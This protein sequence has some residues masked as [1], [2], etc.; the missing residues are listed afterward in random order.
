M[1]GHESDNDEDDHDETGMVDIGGGVKL[2]CI[3]YG[4]AP[5]IVFTHGLGGYKEGSQTKTGP[6][7]KTHL[8]DKG[9]KVVASAAV[10]HGF[11][12]VLYTS[13]G[14]G[15]SIGWEA[16]AIGENFQA[17]SWAGLA[18]DMLVF[19]SQAEC[20]TFIAGGASMG[21]ATAITAALQA[22]DRMRGLLLL[23]VPRAWE[24]RNEAAYAHKAQ[25]MRELG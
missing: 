2:P 9:C 7:G 16:G 22:P 6:A 14:S 13:R 10:R 4:E 18:N 12:V 19:A 20:P 11:G 5:L 15:K 8:N 24:A 17:F 3:R 23:Q 1:E 21:C 25:L